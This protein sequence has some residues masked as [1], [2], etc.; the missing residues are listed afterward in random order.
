MIVATM[1]IRI[2]A[3]STGFLPNLSENHPTNGKDRTD[4][5]DWA[6]LMVPSIT[7]SGFPK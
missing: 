1:I 4:P 5:I 7:P 2:P 3:R 6:A